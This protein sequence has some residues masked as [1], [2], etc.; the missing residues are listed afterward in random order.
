MRNSSSP[1]EHDA[2]QR[3][4]EGFKEAHAGAMEI[5]KLRPDQRDIWHKLA[6]MAKIAEGQAYDLASQGMFS[7]EGGEYGG[8]KLS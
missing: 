4:A 8:G 7:R 1:K 3:M 2:F 5:A 6:A